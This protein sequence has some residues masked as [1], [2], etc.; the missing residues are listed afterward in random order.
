M[1]SEQHEYNRHRG[2]SSRRAPKSLPI[3]SKQAARGMNRQLHRTASASQK[4]R[5]VVGRDTGSITTTSELANVHLPRAAQ[6]CSSHYDGSRGPPTGPIKTTI[7]PPK[8]AAHV[9][10]AVVRHPRLR[11]MGTGGGAQSFHPRPVKT[12]GEDL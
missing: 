4:T 6:T 3:T 8:N 7:D 9:D 1:Q 2:D 10:G 12:K 5:E 11:R